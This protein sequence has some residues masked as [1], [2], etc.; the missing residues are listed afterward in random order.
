MDEIQRENFRQIMTMCNAD[1]LDIVEVACY[2]LERG[3][4]VRYNG[5]GNLIVQLCNTKRA[6]GAGAAGM[7]CNT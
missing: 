5:Q 7:K 1:Y 4:T 2:A 6:A 3:F